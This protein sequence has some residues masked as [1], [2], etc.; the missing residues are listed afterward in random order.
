VTQDS[1]YTAAEEWRVA[2]GGKCGLKKINNLGLPFDP[3]LKNHS[4]LFSEELRKR[5]RFLLQSP[6]SCAHSH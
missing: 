4:Q 2:I 3:A 1:G 5:R 6:A